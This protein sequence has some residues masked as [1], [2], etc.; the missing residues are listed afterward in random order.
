M[1]KPNFGR[2]L[3]LL[4]HGSRVTVMGETVLLF[5]N[6]T[7]RIV[8]DRSILAARR[9]IIL[10]AVHFGIQMDLLNLSS[11]GDLS[12]YTTSGEWDLVGMPAA[13]YI[14]LLKAKFHY[15]DS[16]GPDRTRPDQTKSAHFV[17]YRLNS[18]TR[19]R[20]EQKRDCL[21]HFLPLLAVC[22]PGSQSARD[23]HALACNFAKY[24]PVKK[25]TH[26][27]SDKPFLI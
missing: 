12:K 7:A 2:P 17:G 18:T 27:L 6:R 24:S 20:P 21:V 15:T 5:V 10:F 22:W 9:G 26:S 1:P 19:A 11:S 8:R 13:R 3:L 4:Y 14:Y 23:N 25:F 16:T